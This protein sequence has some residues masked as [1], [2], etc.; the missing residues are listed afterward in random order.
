M[1]SY[2]TP[3]ML[4]PVPYISLSVSSYSIESS[5]LCHRC[6][7]VAQPMK[8]QRVSEPHW[9]LDDAYLVFLCTMLSQSRKV[10]GG[11]HHLS[12]ISVLG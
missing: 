2:A 9:Q 10:G 4:V 6:P 3:C 12:Q 1:H 11:F 8:T 7:L 5:F